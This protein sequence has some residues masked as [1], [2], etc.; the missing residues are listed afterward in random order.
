VTT[1]LEDYSAMNED[2]RECYYCEST[3]YHY[4]TNE[5]CYTDCNM[6]IFCNDDCYHDWKD[7]GILK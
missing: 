6:Y 2:T 1:N 3:I 5:E 7:G 4:Q